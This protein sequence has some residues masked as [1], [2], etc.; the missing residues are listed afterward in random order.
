MFLLACCLIASVKVNGQGQF[1]YLENK[2]EAFMQIISII[3]LLLV[4][5]GIFEL[6]A[7]R[8]TLQARQKKASGIQG[9]V[10]HNIPLFHAQVPADRQS[11]SADQ[12]NLSAR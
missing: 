9:V 2:S 11:S 7:I 6:R 3:T 8:K 10:N 1:P 4:G 5:I 12:S